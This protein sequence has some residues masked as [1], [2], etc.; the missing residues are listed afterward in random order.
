[1]VDVKSMMGQLAVDYKKDGMQVKN[2]L[3]LPT[4]NPDCPT[5]EVVV[6]D[7]TAQE[8]KCYSVV[9]RDYKTKEFFIIGDSFA[10]QG[11]S[12]YREVLP[13]DVAEKRAVGLA[14]FASVFVTKFGV[15]PT[16]C[17]TDFW[18]Y[19]NECADQP[20][21]SETGLEYKPIQE[22]MNATTEW[23]NEIQEIK[24]FGKKGE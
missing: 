10:Y 13:Q 2:V 3:T 21:E 4:R 6:Q 17:A 1:M 22:L 11:D 7:I 20:R 5:I 9:L 8:D 23:W 19:M 14:F 18:G 15:Y 24:N 12:K 16:V